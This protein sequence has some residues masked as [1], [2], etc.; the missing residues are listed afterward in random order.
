VPTVLAE[1]K[2]ARPGFEVVA[3]IF[4]CPTDDAEYARSVGR[5]L[6]TAYLTVPVYAAFH[7]WLGR[8]PVLAPMWRA[9]AGGDRKA[10]LA[11]IPDAL[12]DELLVH[13]SPAECNERLRAY[14]EAGIQ[15]PVIALVSPPG[16]TPETL[17]SLLTALAP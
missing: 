6:L 9:W 12:V 13:G 2:A 7:R 16:L 5:R 11:A 8:E 3:R 1:T 14:T 10:A 17:P 15:V 4:V